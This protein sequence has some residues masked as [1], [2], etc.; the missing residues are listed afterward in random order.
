[1]RIF[2]LFRGIETEMGSDRCHSAH[3]RFPR[4]ARPGRVREGG[5]GLAKFRSVK[6]GLSNCFWEIKRV[7]VRRHGPEREKQTFPIGKDKPGQH[8]AV[9]HNE[10][11]QQQ[12]A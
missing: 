6:T 7:P 5:K 12:L 3:G 9:H 11:S 2:A 10:T 4:R 8:L 1:M